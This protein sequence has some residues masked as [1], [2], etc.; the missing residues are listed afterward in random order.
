MQP[1]CGSADRGA[2]G[3][4]LFPRNRNFR[5]HRQF[6][7]RRREIDPDHHR[8]V[9]DEPHIAI[10]DD[11]DGMT[12]E[13]LIAAMRPGSR[14]PLATRDEPD[15]GRFG[16]GLKSASFSQCRRLTVVPGN[17][18]GPLLRSGIST[19]LQRNEWAVQLPTSLG[20]PNVDQAGRHPEPS[21]SGR[22][23]IADRGLFAQ[24]SQACR[25]HQPENC[26][27]GT[28]SAPRVPSV[29][30]GRE[31]AANLAERPPA[32]A[33]GSLSPEEPGHDSRSG[34]KLTLIHGATWKSRASRFRTT[35]R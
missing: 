27:N 6:D 18:A 7:H 31:T 2:E 22:S 30:G 9:S 5:H 20:I 13:E 28:A 33:T 21:S 19:T 14:N 34:R 8:D 12:E 17:L 16:L 29:H 11:G 26:R 24:C 23:L 3:Y 1:T 32:C 25:G 15:L 10:I 4:R 35:S